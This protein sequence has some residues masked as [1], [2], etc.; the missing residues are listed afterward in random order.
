MSKTYIISSG[1][2]MDAKSSNDIVQWCMGMIANL[3]SE[4]ED[5]EYV[6]Q[7]I[8]LAIEQATINERARIIKIVTLQ[9]SGQEAY[10]YDKDC[11]IDLDIYMKEKILEE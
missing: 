6:E 11:F 2:L 9:L 3:I 1:G 10:D 7:Q 5:F 4:E 8:K